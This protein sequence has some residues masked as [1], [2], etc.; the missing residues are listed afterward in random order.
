MSKVGRC[1]ICGIDNLIVRFSPKARH[2]KCRRCSDR[3]R[4]QER[5]KF[6]YC[7]LCGILKRVALRVDENKPVCL[8]C[9]RSF[10]R[11]E[12]KCEEC[13]KLA[14]LNRYKNF[15]KLCS[16]CTSRYRMKDGASFE[17][18]HRCGNKRP[19]AT[20]DSSGRAV[21]YNCYYKFKYGGS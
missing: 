10:F 21:C 4:Y 2:F 13:G 9:Y 7:S 6:E 11:K 19:V 3:L 16:T 12:E 14:V 8:N 1:D 18:C 20:R 15:I 17:E 5:P